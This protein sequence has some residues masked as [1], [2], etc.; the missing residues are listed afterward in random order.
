MASPRDSEADDQS[1]R[2]QELEQEVAR[3]MH[4]VDRYRTATEDVLQQLD[5]CIGYFVGT[6]KSAIAKSLSANRAHVR[7]RLLHREEN[8]IPTTSA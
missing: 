1:T 2:L 5:W 3:L 8:E 7:R 4:E 6:N